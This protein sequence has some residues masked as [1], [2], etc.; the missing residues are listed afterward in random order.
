MRFEFATSGRIIFGAGT[1]NLLSGIASSLGKSIF[2]ATNLPDEQISTLLGSLTDREFHVFPFSVSGEPTLHII[3][4]GVA[5]A[6][7]NLCDC[8]IGVGGGS[9]ID[10]GKAVAALITNPGTLEDYLEVVGKGLPITKEPVPVIAIPTTSGTGAEVTRN[11]VIGMPE[12]RVKVSLRHPW[13]LPKFA[14]VDPEL[15][16]GL[17]PHITASTG[18]DALTQLIEPYVS[19]KANPLT[20]AICQEGIH[21]IACSLEKAYL[22]D[23]PVSR[24]N[25]SMA[26]LFGGMVLANS[27]LGAVHG[28]AS[29]LGGM[30]SIP[31]GVICAR[32]LPYVV[33]TNLRALQERMP[34]SPALSRYL[35]V[36][37]ILTGN[38]LANEPDGIAW[39]TSLGGQLKIPHL[40]EYP[41]NS[42]EYPTIIEKT[43]QASSTKANPIQLSY[44][45]LWSIL[46][47][48]IN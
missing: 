28:F 29:V 37:R 7:R 33:E 4:D 27:G 32:L 15:T 10:T 47:A 12:Q 2:L 17:P 18:M 48:A 45:E 35:D 8:V 19:I 46:R 23:D 41:I 21:L 9:A 25:M 20:D 6:R 31:H 34:D 43:M 16:H 13:L 40:A 42:D 24:E 38:P 44:D 22:D 36:T 1:A 3:T 14:L 39:I 5:Y 30:Y 26:S 11:A